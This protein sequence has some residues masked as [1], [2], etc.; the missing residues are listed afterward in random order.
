MC[1]FWQPT[2][3][4]EVFGESLQNASLYSIIPFVA[5]AVSTNVAGWTADALASRKC[6][7]MTAIRKTM[8]VSTSSVQNLL[9]ITMHT[10]EK[11]QSKERKFVT[12]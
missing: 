1:F 8:Q 11:L 6:M 9:P 7:G 3:Y 12:L 4:S 5:A 2:Y 10:L